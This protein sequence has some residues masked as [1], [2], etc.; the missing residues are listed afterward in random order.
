ME[1]LELSTYV[2]PTTISKIYGWYAMVRDGTRGYPKVP[3]PGTSYR[4]PSSEIWTFPFSILT[5]WYA[6]V[7]KSADWPKDGSLEG[8][9]SIIIY[10]MDAPGRWNGKEMLLVNNSTSD[11]KTGNTWKST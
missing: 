8:G 3:E 9:Q 2:L 10:L 7:R 1:V 6:V 5:F 4:V 11:A